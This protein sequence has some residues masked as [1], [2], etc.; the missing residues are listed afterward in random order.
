MS[1][2]GGKWVEEEEEEVGKHTEKRRGRGK[3]ARSAC[4]I[5]SKGKRKCEGKNM[6]IMTRSGH[7]GVLR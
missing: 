3:Q 7:P 2:S 1:D 5:C 4:I 6:M